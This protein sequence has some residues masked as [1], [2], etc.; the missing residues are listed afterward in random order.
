MLG[1]REA[2]E[3]LADRFVELFV[4]VDF[5]GRLH[6]FVLLVDIFVE[7]DQEVIQLCDQLVERLFW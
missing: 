1:K 4:G 5:V 6:L 7:T 2:A 3:A